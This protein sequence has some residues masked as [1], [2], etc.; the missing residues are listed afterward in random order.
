[1]ARKMLRTLA[2][3]APLS[4]LIHGLLVMTVTDD[5]TG[6]TCNLLVTY[7]YLFAT[8]TTTSTTTATTATKTTSSATT[9]T[10]T[11]RY[12]CSNFV[13]SYSGKLAHYIHLELR[14]PSSGCELNFLYNRELLG[15]KDFRTDSLLLTPEHVLFFLMALSIWDLPTN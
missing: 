5:G 7:L 8:T 4:S 14:I 3:M 1:M 11:F 9:A 6:A 12:C 10:T 2:G 13:R 15:I